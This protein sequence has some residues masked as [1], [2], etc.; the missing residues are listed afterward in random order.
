M[1]ETKKRCDICGE[2]FDAKNIE[3]HKRDAHGQKKEYIK[4]SKFK[5]S[6]LI[7]IGGI[8]AAIVAGG[9]YWAS[10]P[11]PSLT[12]Q[13][14]QCQSGE[15][16]AFHVHM[17][18]DIF[19]NGQPFVIP[20]G[21]GIIPDRCF[22]WLHTHDNSGVIHIESPLSRT[23]TLGQ[24][25]S[26]WGKTLNNTQIFDNV[27]SGNNTLSVYINGNKVNGDYRDIQLNK[28]DEIAIVYGAPPASIP[29]SY[30]FPQ[31]L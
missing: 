30:N 8:I 18:L 5:F 25:F 29:S 1:S 26:I 9:A 14:V 10:I 16:N 22:Y 12:I 11:S 27:V 2:M 21:T 23:F 13:G 4:R 15:M 6:K 3:Q 31:G 17:H 28:H 24:F 7:I 19:I 20:A